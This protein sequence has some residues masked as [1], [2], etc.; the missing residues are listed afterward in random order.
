MT[1]ELEARLYVAAIN[2]DNRQVFGQAAGEGALR[3]L[4][5]LFSDRWVYVAE[6]LQNA[7]DEGATSIRFAVEGDSLVFEHDGHTFDEKD[8]RGLCSQGLST[9]GAGTVGF[10]GVGF[11]SVYHSFQTVQVSSDVW[12]FRLRAPIEYGERY[13][14]S[15]RDWARVMYPEW[16]E[17][18]SNVNRPYTCRFIFSERLDRLPPVPSDLEQ[19]LQ[20]DLSLL[21][22][23][24]R[25][26][27]RTLDWNG[28][29]WELQEVS[30]PLNHR[31]ATAVRITA[32][33][34]GSSRFWV[35]F[36]TA[37]EPI[38]NAVREFLAHRNLRPK[39]A[40]EREK[41]YQEA[42]RPRTVELF[43]EV[44]E[45]GAPVLP[46]VG[47]V[48]AVLPIGLSL[49]MRLHLQADWLLNAGRN[50][51][52]NLA[53]SVWH[54]EILAQVPRLLSAYLS[55]LVT[56]APVPNWEAG[57]DAL[58]DFTRQES[59]ITALLMQEGFR[60]ALREELRHLKWLPK[61]DGTTFDSPAKALFAPRAFRDFED[62]SW[63]PRSLLGPRAVAVSK[64]GERGYAMVQALQLEQPLTPEQLNQ[65]WGRKRVSVW[66]RRVSG[67]K[68]EEAVVRLLAALV[69]AH[70]DDNTAGWLDTSFICVP[71]ES[72]GWIAPS[73]AR[74][75]PPN[76]R[77]V[78]QDPLI[79]AILRR[80][81]VGK[82]RL[83][84]RRLIDEAGKRGTGRVG[85][86][87]R[88]RAE[89][90]LN[91]LEGI[92]LGE[93][94]SAW[95][96]D[97]PV[98]PTSGQVEDVLHFTRWARKVDP[99][100]F[101][102][103]KLVAKVLAR[104]G[105]GRVRLVTPDQSV[106]EHPY[107]L[108]YR[109][110]FY[111]ELPSIVPDYLGTEL[112]LESERNA[113]SLF[114]EG[115]APRPRGHFYL[116]VIRKQLTPGEFRSRWPH[117][118]VPELKK[119]PDFVRHQEAGDIDNEHFSI[120]DH[121]LPDNFPLQAGESIERVRAAVAW[122]AN[123]SRDFFLKWAQAK[124]FFFPRHARGVTQYT[125]NYRLHAQWVT[126][127]QNGV[128][129]PVRGE[130]V[131]LSPSKLLPRPDRTRPDAPVADLPETLV[132]T[133]MQAGVL[134]GTEIPAAPIVAR[135][136]VEGP[137]MTVRELI[138][139]LRE[140]RD[141]AAKDPRTMAELSEVLRTTP[142][143]PTGEGGAARISH[144]RVILRGA[145][146]GGR[147]TLGDFLLEVEAFEEGSPERELLDA[148]HAEAPFEET[149]TGRQALAYL[150]EQ[151]KT[152]PDPEEIRHHMPIAYAYVSGALEEGEDL[153]DVWDEV[154]E[155]AR[156]YVT[157]RRK[158][159]TVADAYYQDLDISA[160]RH[161]PDVVNDFAIVN[162]RYLGLTTE[163]QALTARLL[164]LPHLSHRVHMSVTTSGDRRASETR[165][166]ALR[167]LRDVVR[168]ALSRAG[169]F[170]LDLDEE[171]EDAELGEQQVPLPDLHEADSLSVSITDGLSYIQERQLNVAYKEGR[172]FICGDAIDFALE[173]NDELIQLWRLERSKELGARIGP[174]LP[175]MDNPDLFASGLRRLRRL[176]GLRLHGDPDPGLSED[177]G[178]FE[179]DNAEGGTEEGS[180]G[181]G[182]SGSDGTGGGPSAGGN[183]RTGWSYGHSGGGGSRR[184][185]TSGSSSGAGS[186][187]YTADTREDLIQWLERRLKDLRTTELVRE[188]V[189][190]E[191]E[192]ETIELPNDT[193]YRQ[194]V[195]AFEKAHG[196][197]PKEMPRTQSG[198]DLESYNAEGRLLRRIEVKGKGLPW[199]G[200][201]V[202]SLSR[203]Q[204]TVAQ[205]HDPEKTGW[206]YW[207][208]VVEE[209]ET[210]NLTV[211]PMQNP[212]RRA[213]RY[214]LRGGTWRW[215]AHEAEVKDVE[216]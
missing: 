77:E 111:P 175:L 149:T 54:D 154:R 101:D 5:Q 103:R 190:D 44:T 86:D 118:Y 206:D 212:S 96:N 115:L 142:L 141:V 57:F 72:G 8:V 59:G 177:T 51:A 20:A 12:K 90:F 87:D 214:E 198:F 133:L 121:R 40:E 91:D 15:Y 130:Q 79:D 179:G 33:A 27:V 60:T 173:L 85:T 125:Y 67:V 211:Y 123:V 138:V 156:V 10:M 14:E 42:S 195:M 24:A 98:E 26:G 144:A 162:P 76:W 28:Q 171:S 19:V 116:S 34:R 104:K 182:H 50:D 92:S 21:P 194:K 191:E 157:R 100:R 132:T 146:K 215:A 55:W 176:L 170:A 39:T 63:A 187:S 169:R 136:Q 22:L 69:E 209:D 192:T 150:V 70:D 16:D 114:F 207:L 197:I 189:E 188:R 82:D 168:E 129:V 167:A 163:Q 25:R 109:R 199:K 93:L 49:P 166:D 4:Q 185:G 202:V 186:G 99:K 105:T 52:R 145:R 18:I 180:A 62:P 11:K 160:L 6:L 110:F 152:A 200:A 68:P 58:P 36:S 164:G 205:R 48:F 139:L 126:Q 43:C 203:Y 75:L 102:A 148:I 137:T 178:H 213:S 30:E 29:V 61:I 113:W 193:K 53:E 95:W 46:S 165:I 64:L 131:A 124:V 3:S 153:T 47:K 127:L 32:T 88:T 74:R 135:L 155:R 181:G 9:K 73:E 31:S 37:Y 107:A 172:I 56:I 196:R 174:L 161:F 84:S 120:Y 158:W 143:I 117:A 147:S 134:F 208:Y 216:S 41:M 106:L 66:T 122:L 23:L 140:A 89:E 81:L 13:G 1:T 7:I 71:T 65:Y 83:V 159:V 78:T 119:G 80:Y 128:W 94:A 204:Y 35:L 38:K 17:S 151:W 108:S 97:L 184:P 201:E 2:E 45:Q 183:R 112:D 210:G